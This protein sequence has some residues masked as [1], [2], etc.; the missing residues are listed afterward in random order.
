MGGGGGDSGSQTHCFGNAMQLD[1]C[2]SDESQSA[3]RAY[4]KA[5]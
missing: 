1:R 4:K 5:S 3:L 2:L